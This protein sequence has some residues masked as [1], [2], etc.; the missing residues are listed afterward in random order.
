M[1]PRSLVPLVERRRES[2][3]DLLAQMVDT[4]CGTFSPEGVNR[5]T[6]LCED[7]FR[8]GGWDV[9]RHAHTPADGEPQLGDLVIGRLDGGAG[10]PR[11]LLIGH[12]D[13]VFP[14][15]TAAERP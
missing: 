2:F 3:L 13:T 12:M 4:D 5:V 9:E 14:D 1:D 15:G 10:G 7:R 11:V 6:D 8:G